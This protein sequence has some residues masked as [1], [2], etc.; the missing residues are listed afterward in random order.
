MLLNDNLA[1]QAKLIFDRLQEQNFFKG[2]PHDA[3][4][5]EITDFYCSTNYLHPF[6]EGNGRTQRA[7]LMQLIRNAGHDLNWSEVDG[8][9]LMIAT[10]QATQ[11]VTDLLRQA[12]GEAIR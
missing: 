12:L 3:F 11:G 1:E 5:E 9:L 6:R 10:I 2:L 8:D 7:F 4:V